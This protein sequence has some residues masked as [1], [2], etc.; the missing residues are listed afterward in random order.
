MIVLKLEKLISNF[1]SDIYFKDTVVLRENFIHICEV[2]DREYDIDSENREA[3]EK[4]KNKM[5]ELLN[6]F[7][8]NDF[9]KMADYLQFALLEEI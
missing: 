4:K 6:V 8:T 5:V 2:F 3:V 7:T 9:I 1:V